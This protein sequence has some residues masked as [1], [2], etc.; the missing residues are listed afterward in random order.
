LTPFGLRYFEL[1]GRELMVSRT[2]YT[3]DLGYELWV[4][5]DDAELLWDRLFTAGELHNIMPMGSDAL[6]LLRIEAGFILAGADFMPAQ[7]TVRPTH[8]RSP[9]ELG[10]SWLVDFKKPLFN[11]RRALLEEKKN[12]SRYAFVKLDI[13]GNK[14]ADNS[15]IYSTKNKNIGWVTSAMWSPSAKKNVALAT[16]E[17]PHGKIGEEMLVEIYYQREL[18]WSRVMAKATVVKDPFFDPPRRRQTP[19]ADW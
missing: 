8:T 6:E 18:K 5:T 17:T 4:D 13:E 9:F 16:V 2:G 11:G 3:G 1:E 12:G 15:Y 7:Q 19:P 14:P 10:L